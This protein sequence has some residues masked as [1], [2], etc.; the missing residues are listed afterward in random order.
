MGS[1][2]I[3]EKNFFAA[4]E[5]EEEA[6]ITQEILPTVLRHLNRCSEE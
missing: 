4:S 2:T 5:G 6:S 3:L 1:P